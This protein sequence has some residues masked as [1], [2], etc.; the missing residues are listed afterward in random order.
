MTALQ[1]LA[2]RKRNAINT[3]AAL[4]A[5]AMERFTREG[6]DSVS[7]R[8]IASDV[9]VDVSLVSRYFGGKD[10]LFADVLAACPSSTDIF[11]GD[12]ATFGERL[13]TKLVDD[14]AEDED[15]T[16]LL[17]I[18]R[19]ASSPKAREAIR[20]SGEE[21]FFGPI[22]EWLG[23]PDSKVRARLIADIVMGVMIDRVISDNFELG[24]EERKRF[25]DR[26]VR[27]IQGAIEI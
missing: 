16:C 3:R 12:V 13:A 6:Y 9:G 20:K 2:A 14:A 19:S 4:L 25:R 8:E 7:L 18:L 21:R 15:L 17:I 22:E 11:E 10:E 1:A 26:L 24:V 27:V 23:G 5:A